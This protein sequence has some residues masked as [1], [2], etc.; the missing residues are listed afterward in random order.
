MQLISVQP[1]SPLHGLEGLKH[2][3]VGDRAGDL[4]SRRWPT[5]TRASPPKRRTSWCAGSRA[6]KD[7]SSARRAARR[8]PRP[9]TSPTRSSEGVIVAIFPDGGDRYLSDHLWDAVEP[10]AT[11]RHA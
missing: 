2:M 4:R 11:T 8:W 7:C 5:S 9:S 1:D 10:T 3:A 6:R